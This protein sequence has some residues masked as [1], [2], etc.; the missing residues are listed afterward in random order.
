VEARE[1]P[2]GPTRIHVDVRVGLPRVGLL[3]SY[4]GIVELTDTRS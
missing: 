1:D 2:A 4:A 3:I